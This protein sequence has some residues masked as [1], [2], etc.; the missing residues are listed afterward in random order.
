MKLLKR[1]KNTFLILLVFLTY[2]GHLVAVLP[3]MPSLPV[4][5]PP[6]PLPVPNPSPP[7]PASGGGT[8]APVVNYAEDYSSI[9]R[10]TVSIDNEVNLA[11]YY[12][13]DTTT[14]EEYIDYKNGMN[15]SPF[16]TVS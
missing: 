13:A 7:A 5:T 9:D 12:F 11:A 16:K 15:V 4:P 6:A 3:P 14:N 10:L 8:S 1:N 2:V